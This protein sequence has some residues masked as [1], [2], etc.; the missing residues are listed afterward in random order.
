MDRSFFAISGCGADG[1]Q[2]SFGC[3]S[4]IP[5]LL[6]R[7]SSLVLNCSTVC[8]LKSPRILFAVEN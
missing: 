8:N 7:D 3:E 4:S 5:T 1:F 6:E 2:R